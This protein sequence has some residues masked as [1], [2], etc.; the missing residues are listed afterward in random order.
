MTY[1]LNNGPFTV[2]MDHDV[3]QV[4]SIL[5]NDIPKAAWWIVREYCI[6][7]KSKT[8]FNSILLVS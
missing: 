8:N 6:N 1:I 2:R 3:V 7:W 5:S 4:V